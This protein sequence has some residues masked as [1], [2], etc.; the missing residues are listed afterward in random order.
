MHKKIVSFI[1]N[2]KNKYTYRDIARKFKISHNSAHGI[3]GRAGLRDFMVKEKTGPRSFTKEKVMDRN[4]KVQHELSL[5]RL[6]DGKKEVDSQYKIALRKI[7]DLEREKQAFVDIHS[8]ARSF[9]IKPAKGCKSE[10]TAVW[11][12]S[13][14]HVGENVTLGQ[15]NGLNRYNLKIAQ[16]RAEAFFRNGLRLTNLAAHDISVNTIVLALLGDFITGHL[17]LDAVENNNLLPVD[18]TLFAQSLIISGIEY[19]LN[20]SEYKLIIPCHSGNHGRTTKFPHF[21]SENGHSLEFFMYNSIAN[22]FR[23]EPRVSMSIPEG[24]HSY[25]DIYGYKIRFLHGHDVKF[26]GGVGGITIPLNKAISQWDKARPAY[27]TCIGH[28]HQRFDGGHFMVNGSLIGYNAFALSIK[29]S[30]ERPQQQ[31]ALIDKVRG[32]TLVA[33]ILLDE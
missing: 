14:W 21:G 16:Q 5:S 15:T 28:F 13:D 27:L 29:A 25:M 19:I 8:G 23:N 24:S 12:A 30:A 2:N 7:A 11:L 32:K 26:G 4:K 3:I 17:H 33:P 31:F 22:Y 18:E 9:V 10:A 6:K 20:N 1:T